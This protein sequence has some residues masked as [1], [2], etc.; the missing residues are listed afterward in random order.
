MIKKHT[1]HI[2]LGLGLIFLATGLNWL[3]TPLLQAESAQ[4][5]VAASQELQSIRVSCIRARRLIATAIGNKH[6]A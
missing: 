5:T 2:L 3:R 6:S 1:W 4:P